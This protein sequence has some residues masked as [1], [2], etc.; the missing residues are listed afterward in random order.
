[1]TIALAA[2]W[3]PRGEL[4]RLQRLMPAL[5]DVYAQIVISLP[6]DA[7]SDVV[8]ML[9]TLVNCD[10]PTTIRMA[11]IINQDWNAGRYASINTALSAGQASHIAYADLDRLLRWVETRPEEWRT[12]MEAIQRHECL[13]FGRSEAAYR[14][15]P[16]A[17]VQT[18]AISNRV[19]SYFLG[20]S[21]DVSAGLKGFSR[22]AAQYLVDHTQPLH[23]LG[24]DAEWTILLKKTGF[25]VDYIA[26]D[27]LDWESADRYQLKA[28]DEAEQRRAAAQYDADPKH[29]A[30]RVEVALEIVQS[31]M[32]TGI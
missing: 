5:T 20:Q 28:A 22:R 4:P 26:V 16:Q 31:A 2:T 29:W 1:M 27:G 19:V 6:P 18:E 24:T 8:E 32:D 21:V 7:P 15:H 13:I 14:T 9:P 23:A 25:P 12:S 3:Q 30:R 17:L 11:V 10:F